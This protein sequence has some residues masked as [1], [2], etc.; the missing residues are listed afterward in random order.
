MKIKIMSD[1][2]FEFHKDGGESFI[3]SIKSNYDI[4]VL[5]GDITTKSNILHVMQRFNQLKKPVVYVPGNHEYYNCFRGDMSDILRECN[6]LKYINA[7]D[8]K[9]CNI[10]G[11][12]FL[13]STLWFKHPGHKQQSDN[14]M[15]CFNMI[16]LF[17]E[18][19]G[20]AA[21]ECEEYIGQ[22]HND[23]DV[24]VTHMIPHPKGINKIYK[25]DPMNKYFLH[26][27]SH[28]V[29][30]SLAKLWVFGHS[31]KS[32]DKQINE[33]TRIVSNPFGYCRYE[34]NEDFSEDLVI[35]V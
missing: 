31:H 30:N 4:L 26:D 12:K 8:N 2:H 11:V 35:D 19:V 25:G 3:S 27:I 14:W 34:E 1:L 7:L 23:V 28:L 10:D 20:L 16:P 17:S 32:C 9:M 21:N 5:A 6:K 18:W 33:M 24:V 13:G 29:E 15:N 22:Y